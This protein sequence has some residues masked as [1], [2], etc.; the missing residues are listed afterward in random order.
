[1][2]HNLLPARMRSLTFRVVAFLSLALLPIG[3]I[4]VKQTDEVTK[5][6]QR[7]TELTLLAV[8]EQAATV[9]QAV[10]QQAFGAARTLGAF[11]QLFNQDAE[12]CQRHLQSFL[13]ASDR[14]SFV[15]FLPKDGVMTC[16]SHGRTVDFSDFPGFADSVA[17]PAPMVNVNQDAPLS[18][19]SVIIISLPHYDDAG[20]FDGY[21]S[22]SVPHY[23]LDI[24]SEEAPNDLV[25]LIT[26]NDE[27]EV[28]TATSDMGDVAD[29]LP[30][31]TELKYLFSGGRQAFSGK[32]VDE[33]NRVFAVTPIVEDTVYALGI[34]SARAPSATGFDRALHPSVFPILMWIACLIVAMFAIHRLV[35]RHVTRLRRRMRAFARTR[36]FRPQPETGRVP[37]ELAEMGQD[38]DQMAEAI[39][40]DEAEL[41]NSLHEKNVLLK[42]VHHRVKNNL[43]LISSIM[44]MEMRK[45]PDPATKKVLRRLQDRV[46]GLATIHRTLYQA[47]SLSQVDAGVLINDIVDQI[48]VKGQVAGTKVKVDRTVD[49]VVLL[50]DQAVPL[51]LLASEAVTNLLKHLGAPEGSPPEVIVEL[52]ESDDGE[53]TLR[54]ENTLG[55]KTVIDDAAESTGLGAQLMNAF[56]RQLG[57]RITTAEED[58]CYR[59]KL[60]FVKTPFDEEPVDFPADAQG[61]AE[62]QK[63]VTVA[64]EPRNTETPGPA[65]PSHA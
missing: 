8:T 18:G 34:W 9:E 33:E 5:E 46:R 17:N 61:D 55:Q 44:N 15:G 35:L 49:S 11:I 58:E 48:R 7:R 29:L 43:Q 45:N 21:I 27:G 52:T 36:S 28:I 54:I 42:E 12:A 62:G 64:S 20:N 22:V 26:F 32:S 19:T 16:S 57:G 65:R 37:L 40:R 47:D 14:F 59:L 3:L 4:A 39:L 56:A 1:M 2:P 41:E 31:G 25:G 13:D 24:D 60:T 63:A 23:R 51:A 30:R 6:T 10:I 53:V 38:F 50:P